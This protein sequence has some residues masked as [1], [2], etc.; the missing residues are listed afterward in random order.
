MVIITIIELQAVCIG[1][2]MSATTGLII[3]KNTTVTL[4][5]WDIPLTSKNMHI[6]TGRVVMK[7]TPKGILKF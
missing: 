4:I 7:G 1:T 6:T 3:R 5:I 2:K